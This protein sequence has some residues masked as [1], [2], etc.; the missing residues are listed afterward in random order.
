MVKR[1]CLGDGCVGLAQNPFLAFYQRW[2]W[3]T[4]NTLLFNLW[5]TPIDIVVDFFF[6]LYCEIGWFGLPSTGTRF[7]LAFYTFICFAVEDKGLCAL[8]L[9]S[10]D[11][12]SRR[13]RC[14]HFPSAST[15][16]IGYFDS[17]LC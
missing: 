3:A 13:V 4:Q 16:L 7:S 14:V 9:V 2:P 12:P 1:N 5:N 10:A 6:A 8:D 11:K 17:D 15:K